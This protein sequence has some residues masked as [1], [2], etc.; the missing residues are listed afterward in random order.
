MNPFHIPEPLRWFIQACIYMAGVGL[1]L[2][3]LNDLANYL[4]SLGP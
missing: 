3:A 1:L 4:E 2:W